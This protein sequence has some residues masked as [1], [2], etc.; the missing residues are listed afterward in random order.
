MVTPISFASKHPTMSS[1]AP[2][3]E[4][5]LA[6]ATFVYDIEYPTATVTSPASGLA[7]SAL[8]Q[9]AG[10][11]V[12][13]FKMNA[14]FITIQDSTT[15]L[16]WDQTSS[17][18]SAVTGSK[19]VYYTATPQSPAIGRHGRG[20]LIRRSYKPA[21]SYTIQV[22]GLDA[23]GNQQPASLECIHVGHSRRRFRMSFSPADGTFIKAGGLTL[24]TGTATDIN[25]IQTLELSIQRLSDNKWWSSSINEEAGS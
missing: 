17:S 15:N 16:W 22:Y 13:D 21:R 6:S 12:E 11:N 18:F 19:E 9:F 8:T 7:I 14:V 1:S 2:N 20:R 4:V 10:T 3:T 24:V 5:N 23:A 25:D